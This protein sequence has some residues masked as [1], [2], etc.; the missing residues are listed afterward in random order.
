M[1]KIFL[2]ITAVLF[3]SQLF[4]QS[5]FEG[6]FGQVSTG[7]EK[8]TITNTAPTLSNSTGSQTFT[9]SGNAISNNMPLVIS[10]GYYFSLNPQFLLGLA[11]DYSAV[12]LTTNAIT[13][14][15]VGF[16]TKS[17]SY[18][19]SNRYSVYIAP[20]LQINKESLAYL[21][22]GY[23]SESLQRN[24]S[25]SSTNVSSS[26]N[27]YILGVG[28]KQIITGG[29]YGFGELNYMGYRQSTMTN[30]SKSLLNG[31][32]AT[33]SISPSANAYNLLVGLGY[34]F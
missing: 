11:A 8:N 17:P 31:Q 19:I 20:A 24:D 2:S 12:T 3:S 4:A 9:T 23:S 5:S 26:L 1:K 15:G 7:Y 30:S 21:K 16:T 6:F 18:Q 34:K 14:S 33:D 29:L 25:N 27:G 28:Y 13:N 22:L 10:G 32:P